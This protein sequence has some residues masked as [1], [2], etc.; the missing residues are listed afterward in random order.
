MT[1]ISEAAALVDGE[2]QSDY[3]DIKTN[4]VNVAKIWSGVLGVEVTAEQ[5]PLCLIGLKLARQSNKHKKDNLVDIV[6]Y[7][8][9]SSRLNE[10]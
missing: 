2:R 10:G 6:G 1:I 8:E 5:V 3:G 4:M 7:A 9:I